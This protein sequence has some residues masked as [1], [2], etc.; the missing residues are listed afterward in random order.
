MAILMGASAGRA[1]DPVIIKSCK[2][3]VQW[4]ERTARN[5]Q[6]ATANLTLPKSAAIRTMQNGRVVLRTYYGIEFSLPENAELD[7]YELS[8]FSR[9]E[10]VMELTAL[11]LQ[12]LPEKKNNPM[13][14]STDFVLHGAMSDSGQSSETM[15]F[16]KRQMNGLLALYKQGFYAGFILKYYQLEL[17][18][19]DLNDPALRQ[20][21]LVSFEKMNM[22]ARYQRLLQ[23]E[24]N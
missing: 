10:L 20:A 8:P 12:S 22:P 9:E 5:W 14:E 21:L 11:E 2:G 23:E 24:K 17:L 18:F 3:E 1:G 7:T 19:P 4:R 15:A 6:R 16:R 13:D